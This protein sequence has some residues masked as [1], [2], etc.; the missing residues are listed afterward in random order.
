MSDQQPWHLL[1]VGRTC[2]H[3][4]EWL[5]KRGEQP[6]A[7]ADGALITAAHEWYVPIPSERRARLTMSAVVSWP[8]LLLRRDPH[9]LLQAAHAG[10]GGAVQVEHHHGV[11]ALAL[12]RGREK[13]RP[14]RAD[15]PVAAQVDAVGPGHALA[16]GAHVQIGVG[17]CADAQRAAMEGRARDGVRVQPRMLSGERIGSGKACQPVSCWLSSSTG[18]TSPARPSAM[19]GP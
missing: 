3:G 15:G 18:S 2:R 9:L 14:L 12:E 1:P 8:L 6:S 5:T 16:E 4:L 19:R 7:C 11:V 17:R 10:L 13:Q